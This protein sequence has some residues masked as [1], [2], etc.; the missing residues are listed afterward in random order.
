MDS[1]DIGRLAYLVL[2]LTAVGGYFVASGRGSLNKMAQQAAIWGL[3]FLGL[4]AGYGLWTDVRHDLAPRQSMVGAGRLEVPRQF[5]GH[6]YVTAAANGARIDF[7]VDTGA[8]DVVLTREDAARAGIDLA[9]LAY[10]G[11]ASTANGIV[12]TARARLPDLTLGGF[13]DQAVPVLVNEGEMDTSLLGM[14]YLRRFEKIEIADD[15][16]I[17]T[18]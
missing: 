18:R 4:V 6:F 7:V 3:I 13:T 14:T 12:R 8:T 10:T 2:L 9:S 5:D 16:L 1:Y 15:K 11:T 17:L